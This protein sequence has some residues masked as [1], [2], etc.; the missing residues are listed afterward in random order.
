M[1]RD[2]RKNQKNKA[3][4]K[5]D[6]AVEENKTNTSTGHGDVSVAGDHQG[7]SEPAR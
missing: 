5:T 1:S 7:S 3:Q 4:P 2:T 6:D